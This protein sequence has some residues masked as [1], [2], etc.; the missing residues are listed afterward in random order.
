MIQYF[1]KKFKIFSKINKVLFRLF[2]I[3]NIVK[4]Q[5]NINL[6]FSQEGEDLILKR[7]F[8][9]KNYGFYIDIGAHH[10]T[11]FSNT[12]IF[13]LAGW[14]GINID[15]NPGIMQKF[16]Q[17]RPRDINLEIAISN[18]KEILTYY[19]FNDSAL[20]TFDESE[21]K[22]KVSDNSIYHIINK[23]YIKTATLKDVLYKFLPNNM[24]IDFITIDA[25]GLDFDI[26]KSNDWEKFRPNFILVEELRS[27]IENICSTS[28]IY[29]FL[30]KNQ[31]E[32]H[33][34]T[35]NTSIYKNLNESK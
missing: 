20:N 10:P 11:R 22:L 34:R 3:F 27:S 28:P 30:K 12:Y 23:T 13:Y 7:I 33:Y 6:S 19:Q 18:S 1:I 26:L 31:Y 9:N 21:A 24:I 29:N 14:N 16:N 15:P 35:Y 8:G 17:L 25:E 2:R 5:N 4:V 32:L